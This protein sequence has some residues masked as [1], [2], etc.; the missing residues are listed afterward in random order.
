MTG[1]ELANALAGASWI[2]LDDCGDELARRPEAKRILER[3][4]LRIDKNWRP[5]TTVYLPTYTPPKSRKR[6]QRP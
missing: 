3:L 1:A 5:H 4:L 6:K 2:T